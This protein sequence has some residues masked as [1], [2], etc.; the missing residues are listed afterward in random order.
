MPAHSDED[1]WVV[2]VSARH[3]GIQ[4]RRLHTRT[5]CRLPPPCRSSANLMLGHVLSLSHAAWAGPHL[6]GHALLTSDRPLCRWFAFKVPIRAS[7]KLCMGSMNKTH[8]AVGD[9]MVSTMQADE[10]YLSS[11]KYPIY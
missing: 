1:Q 6:A 9:S 10:V 3:G 7:L 11:E 5:D 2:H 4:T 8:P